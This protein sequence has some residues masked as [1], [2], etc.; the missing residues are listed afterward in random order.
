MNG[1]TWPPSWPFQIVG[2]KEMVFSSVK[3]LQRA[4]KFNHSPRRVQRG[5]EK[6]ISF[7][8]S[9]VDQG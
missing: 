2:G 8:V 3:N 7:L 6:G 5:L 1:Y 9:Q 4:E